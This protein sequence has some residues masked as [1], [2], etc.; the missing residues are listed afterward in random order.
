MRLV[1]ALTCLLASSAAI[2][3]ETADQAPFRC[4]WAKGPIEIDGKADDAAWKSAQVIDR[5]S[6]PW[7]K[8]KARPAKTAT[9]ARLLWDRE[10]LYFFA[11]LEDAD[12]FAPLTE[13]DGRL[14]DNDVFELFFKPDEKATGY[15]EFQVNAAGAVLECSSPS[16][17]KSSS[18]K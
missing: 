2:A 12:L 4:R 11:D 15:Y 3:Q 16:G 5:F 17:A 8:E 10:Y 18:T 6:L 14:W 7:L 9:K 1:L 13:H